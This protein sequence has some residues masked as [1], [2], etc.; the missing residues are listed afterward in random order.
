MV[1]FGGFSLSH[2]RLLRVWRPF[3]APTA[4]IFGINCREF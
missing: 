4:A 1:V 2:G 3:L